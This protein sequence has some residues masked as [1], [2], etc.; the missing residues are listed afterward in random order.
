LRHGEAE[1]L[2]GFEINDQ[3]DFGGLL[4]RQVT[5]LL[6][7]E[8]PSGVDADLTVRVRKTSSIAR[9]AAGCGERAKLVDRGYRVTDRQDAKLFASTIES[10]VK[11]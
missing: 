1:R 2:R 10:V 7:L 9:Q 3:L 4:D 11:N 5:R 6:A 8:Y